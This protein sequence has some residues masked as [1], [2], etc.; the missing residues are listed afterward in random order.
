MNMGITSPFHKG[1]FVNVGIL[2]PAAGLNH[3]S[4][5]P[6]SVPVG[7]ISTQADSLTVHPGAGTRTG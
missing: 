1:L 4:V 7:D 2:F 3:E 6:T 5:S